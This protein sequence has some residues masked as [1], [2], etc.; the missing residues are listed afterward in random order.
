M[1]NGSVIHAGEL[2]TR[3]TAYLQVARSDVTVNG[4]MLRAGDGARL[5]DEHDIE[6]VAQ[7]PA[8]ILLFDLP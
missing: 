3:R 5:C 8:E 1:G 2:H 7:T 6:L 4:E